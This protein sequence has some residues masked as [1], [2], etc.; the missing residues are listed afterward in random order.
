MA[1]VRRWAFGLVLLLAL[2]GIAYAEEA[3]ELV[4]GLAEAEEAQAEGADAVNPVISNVIE[5]AGPTILPKCAQR[6]PREIAAHCS[7]IA[8]RRDLYGADPSL[9]SQR[10]RRCVY[11]W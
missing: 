11:H 6:C 7:G 2:S 3:A 9:A 10:R 5:A 8:A 1:P 4:P